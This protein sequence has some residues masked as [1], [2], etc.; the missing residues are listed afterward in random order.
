MILM[1]YL[2][3]VV[4]LF[5]DLKKNSNKKSKSQSQEEEMVKLR[6]QKEESEDLTD[7]LS[8]EGDEEVKEGKGLKILT[9]KKSLARLPILLAHIKT[10]GT[11]YKL[12]NE[13]S[14]ILYLLYQHNK[15]TKKV[16]NNLMK[17]LS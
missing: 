3:K 14:Q 15:I 7:M 13:I 10:E 17:S 5:I 9:P 16:Y 12:K 6:R 4:N 11:S 2:L 1:I 8:L